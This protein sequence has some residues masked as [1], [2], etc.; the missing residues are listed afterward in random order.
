MLSKQIFGIHNKCMPKSIRKNL[1]FTNLLL[2]LMRKIYLKINNAVTM[3]HNYLLHYSSLDSRL[4][5]S[6]T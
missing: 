3:Y 2:L 1:K 6:H 4:G 5:Y